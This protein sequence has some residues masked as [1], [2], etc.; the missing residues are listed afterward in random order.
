M[1]IS[2]APTTDNGGGILVDSNGLL[3]LTDS[4][5]VDNVADGEAGSGP[6]AR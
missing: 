1:R 6:M 5:V 2:T 4:E 3:V